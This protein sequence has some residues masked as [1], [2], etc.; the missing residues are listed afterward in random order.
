MAVS[1]WYFTRRC[2]MPVPDDIALHAEWL[3]CADQAE[4]FEL[5]VREYAYERAG[6]ARD[7]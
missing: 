6:A 7:T 1:P 4:F 3:G 5:V 2:G